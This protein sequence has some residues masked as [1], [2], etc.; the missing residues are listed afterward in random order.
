MKSMTAFG[1]AEVSANNG[2]LLRV[3]ISSYNKKQL[4]IRMTLPKELGSFEHLVRKTVT[5]FIK[6]G[7]VNLKIELVSPEAAMARNVVINSI[8]AVAYAKKIESLRK[9]LGLSSRPVIDTILGLPGVIQEI[10][11]EQLVGE[12]LLLRAL[13]K[14]LLRMMKMRQA[15]GKAMLRD[16]KCRLAVLASI[17]RK[18]APAARKLPESQMRRIRD[19]LAQLG[20]GHVAEDDRILKEVVIFADRFDVSEEI[21]RLESHFAQ[22]EG[23]FGRDDPVGRPLE[24]LLQEMQ[25]EINTL[26]N[27]APDVKVSPLVVEFKTELEK[28]REQV[29]NVE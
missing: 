11:I 8:V 27:K 21:T 18:I 25:R 3:D 15:E 29:Q 12:R 26:G 24:F 17:I 7:A 9:Q 20:V 19:N 16:I 1:C 5:S 28:I 10:S 6:R 23:L 14:A 13:K 4:E 22:F 2:V